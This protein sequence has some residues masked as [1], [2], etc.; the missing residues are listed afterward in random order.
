M[1]LD[2]GPAGTGQARLDLVAAAG[3]EALHTQR[4]VAVTSIAKPTFYMQGA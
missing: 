3:V 4:R 2:R 1:D